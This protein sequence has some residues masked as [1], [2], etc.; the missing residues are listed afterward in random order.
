MKRRG[1]S[2]LEMAIVISILTVLLSAAAM[3]LASL[4]MHTGRQR[5]T[6]HEA[7]VTTRF[8]AALRRD[9]H[10][11]VAIDV[12]AAD[13]TP[14]RLQLTLPGDERVE[15]VVG[16][17]GVERLLRN[18]DEVRQTELYRLPDLD[19][20]R[21]VRSVEPGQAVICVWQRR[22]HGPQ[23]IK[24]DDEAALRSHRFVAAARREVRDE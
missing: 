1:T 21:F 20:M 7:Q 4:V 19:A 10:E 6:Y 14:A 12:S 15:Y 17:S 3:L 2:L 16:V 23:P 8:A 11:A 18:G 13:T 24:Q 9:V 5:S 22:W